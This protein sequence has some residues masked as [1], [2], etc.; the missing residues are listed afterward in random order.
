[1]DHLLRSP[2]ELLK[3]NEEDTAGPQD[4]NSGWS[5]KYL[6]CSLSPASLW[7]DA[8]VLSH[9]SELNSFLCHHLSN[10]Q[11]WMPFFFSPCLFL[12]LMQGIVKSNCFKRYN[13]VLKLALFINKFCS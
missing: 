1:M 2:G 6:E 12:F 7:M 8:E 13:S 5:K 3:D 4:R 9:N 11:F 10:T